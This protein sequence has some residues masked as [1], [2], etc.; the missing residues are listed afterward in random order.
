MLNI[1]RRHIAECASHGKRTGQKCTKKPP[2]PIHVEGVDGQGKRRKPQALIDPRTGNGIRDW[3]RAIEV[4]RDLEAPTPLLVAEKRNPIQTAIDHFLKLKQCKARDTYRKNKAVVMRLKEFMAASP[5]NFQFVTEIGFH[6]LTDFCSNW[7]GAVRSKVRDLGIL[8][9]FLKYCHRSGFTASNIGD[10]L[11]RELS[12]R[13]DEA[14]KE[15]FRSSATEPSIDPKEDELEMVWKAL[16]NLPDAYGRRAQPIA[17]QTEAFVL[18]MRYTG[19]DVSTTMTLPKSRVRGNKI[20][21]YRLK[22]GN[23]VST[24]VPEWVTGKL[25]AAPHDSEAYFFWSGNGKPH[26]RASKWFT[27]LRKVLDLAGLP[28][29]TPHN[30]RHHFAVEQLL[31][32]T[33]IVEVSRLLGHNDITVTMRSYGAWVKARQDKME[34]QQTQV[35]EHDPLHRR[36]NEK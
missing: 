21:T 14:P 12:W 34:A 33:D 29:R 20:L 19:M 36:M 2:C 23:E 15:P 28:H 30:F 26:T 9:S 6:D 10:G 27:R 3:A 18:L 35:W 7:Q 31:M 24:I 11:F 1:F 13:D 16:S 25:L 5:R 4:L 8:T 32:G 17:R 22:N